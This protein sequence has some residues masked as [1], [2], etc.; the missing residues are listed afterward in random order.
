[1]LD[2]YGYILAELFKQNTHLH[3]K[4]LWRRGNKTKWPANAKKIIVTELSKY[5]HDG[6]LKAFSG[7]I[8]NKL[9][10]QNITTR[11]IY[12]LLLQWALLLTEKGFLCYY[13]KDYEG[14]IEELRSTLESGAEG[15]VKD[16]PPEEIIEEWEMVKER[17]L[18]ELHSMCEEWMVR[19]CGRVR[20]TGTR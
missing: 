7:L 4:E 15:E 13:T 3:G 2:V 11:H 8:W 12:G 18:M 6:K 9:R 19:N 5:P 20:F 14:L 1:M 17:Y 10:Q 16:I